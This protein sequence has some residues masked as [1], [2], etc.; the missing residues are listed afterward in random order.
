MRLTQPG[1][2]TIEKAFGIGATWNLRVPSFSG[3]VSA[4]STSEAG[5]ASQAI[6]EG[7]VLMSPLGMA[8]VAADVD[9]GV[10][11]TPTLVSSDSSTAWRMPLSAAELTALRGL[12]RDAVQSGPARAANLSGVPVYG[13]AGVV[14][15]AAHDYLSWFVGY[16]GELAFTVVEATHTQAQAAA[17]LA[18]TFLSSMSSS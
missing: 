4:A 1:L 16:R 14:Q 9:S 13:Q 3:S 11:H 7:G 15:T 8:V 5:L 18:A 6:G 10:G 12:M 17:A 2:A